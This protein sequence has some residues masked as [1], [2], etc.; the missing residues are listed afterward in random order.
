MHIVYLSHDKKHKNIAIQK[1]FYTH[2]A[3]KHNKLSCLYCVKCLELFAIHHH[4]KNP[5]TPNKVELDYNKLVLRL[6]LLKC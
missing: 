1:T 5:Q 2:N 3:A 4:S 6:R